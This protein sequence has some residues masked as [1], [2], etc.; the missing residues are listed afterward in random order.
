MTVQLIGYM[1]MHSS[2]IWVPYCIHVCVV[3]M[4]LLITNNTHPRTCTTSTH[5][6][7]G[8]IVWTAVHGTRVQNSATTLLCYSTAI[9][10]ATPCTMYVDVCSV[11][12]GMQ[13]VLVSAS[14]LCSPVQV[15]RC[16]N[17]NTKDAVSPRR[18]NFAQLCLRALSHGFRN[19]LYILSLCCPLVPYG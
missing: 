8:H 15:Q 16:C 11:S 2:P 19:Y 6:P 10:I 14:Y 17:R 4:S 5:A 3:Y 1:Q 12:A 13:P 9:I 7:R 18:Q